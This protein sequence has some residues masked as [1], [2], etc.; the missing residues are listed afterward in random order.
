MIR[1]LSDIKPQ[2]VILIFLLAIVLRMFF[3]FLSPESFVELL[4]D[5]YVRLVET[6]NLPLVLTTFLISTSIVLVT[7]LLLNKIAIRHEILFKSNY[8]PAYF[9]LLLTS[10]NTVHFVSF[11]ILINNLILILVLDRI[12]RLYKA[13]LA[14]DNIFIAAFLTG[15]CTGLNIYFSVFFILL[16][17]GTLYFRTFKFREFFTAILGFFIPVYLIA[18]CSYLIQDHWYYST[19]EWN[20]IYVPSNLSSLLLSVLPVITVIIFLSLLRLAN[21]YWRN[22]IKSRRITQIIIIY[23]VLGILLCFTNDLFVYGDI[24]HLFIPFSIILAYYFTIQ[25]GR[26]KVKEIINLFLLLCIF[27]FQFMPF[28]K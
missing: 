22:T 27:I 17:I 28:V 19:I 6:Y 24:T 26:F 13:N 7:A 8:L 14:Y 3:L 9:Y 2:N 10:I 4:P 20:K 21:N 16:L 23:L 1:F 5:L 15:L 11:E 12:F 18:I 25:N